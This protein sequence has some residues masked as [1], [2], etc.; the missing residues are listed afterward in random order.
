MPN[1]T[2]NGIRSI[3][4]FRQFHTSFQ[5]FSEE[6]DV[7][8]G[9][10]RLRLSMSEAAVDLPHSGRTSEASQR[11]LNID[12]KATASLMDPAQAW[13]ISNRDLDVGVIERLRLSFAESN[14]KD[15]R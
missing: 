5:D 2:L 1:A 13:Y 3:T 7:L 12:L 9:L 15:W 4:A 14:E 6:I 11:L 8:A 10:I